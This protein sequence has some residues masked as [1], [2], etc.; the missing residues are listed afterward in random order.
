MGRAG[1]GL[2][3]E[4]QDGTCSLCLGV[5]CS[6]RGWEPISHSAS[7]PLGDVPSA[8]RWRWWTHGRG[9]ISGHWVSPACVPG[10]VHGLCPP[11][12]G[13]KWQALV[14]TVA[15]CLTPTPSPSSCPATRQTARGRAPGCTSEH[16]LSTRTLPVSFAPIGE[17]KPL[18]LAE[19]LAPCPLL[20]DTPHSPALWTGCC[21]GNRGAVPRGSCCCSV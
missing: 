11:D 18:S 19:S 14:R 7:G 3:E 5:G 8:C 9:T 16:A 12:S 15:L 2:R 10:A 17:C 13:F 4:K 6:G 20:P 21:A 1:A